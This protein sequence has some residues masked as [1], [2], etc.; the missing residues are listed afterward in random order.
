IRKGT[1]RNRNDSEEKR[2][3]E[4]LF[5][6]EPFLRETIRNRDDS[7]STTRNTESE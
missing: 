6:I 1:I 5:G 4:K 2:F 7:N 3:E